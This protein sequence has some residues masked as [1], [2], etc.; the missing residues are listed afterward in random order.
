MFHLGVA[1]FVK[2]SHTPVKAEE[3]LSGLLRK[4]YA[5]EVGIVGNTEPFDE[6]EL[7]SLDNEGRCVI[8]QHEFK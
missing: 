4:G 6:E 2:D 1:T 7:T 5:D 8:T 3:G